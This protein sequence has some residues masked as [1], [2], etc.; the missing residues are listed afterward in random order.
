MPLLAAGSR[1]ELQVIHWEQFIAGDNPVRVIDSF[2][3][4]LDLA[5][6]GFV[7]KGKSREGRPAFSSETLLKLYLYGYLNRCR[8]SR[9]LMRA[10]QTNIELFWLLHEAKPCYKTIAD[11]R[12]NN[13]RALTKTFSTFSQ[14]L[15]GEGLLQG[16]TV[17]VDGTKIA[18]QNSKKN[19][20]NAKKIKRH[21][22]YIDRQT[23]GYLRE[24][25]RLDATE[26]TEEEQVLEIAEKLD[27]LHQR[28]EKYKG[29]EKQLNAVRANHQAQIST[30]DPEARA[31]P[32]KMNIVEVS[33]NIQT[34]VESDHKLITNFEVT[35]ENDTHALS[36]M[37]IEAKAV[38][39]KERIKVLADKGYDTESELKTCSEN[40]I[41]TYV[42][43]R[44]KNTSK[45][46]PEFVKAQ[47]IYDP[48]KDS[49]TCPEN[50]ELRSNGNRYKKNVKGHRKAYTVQ[51]YKLPLAECKDCVHRLDCVGQANLDN[52]KGRRIERSE[53]DDYLE[54][55]RE[56]VKLHKALYRTRQQ[57]V[58]HPFGTIKR[59]W[60]YSYTLLKTKEKVAAEMAL[61][62]TCYN[63]RRSMSIFGVS[64]LVKR[65]KAACLHILGSKAAFLSHLGL[66]FSKNRMPGIFLLKKIG[67]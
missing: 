18:A 59:G 62:F 66:V 14:F 49:Y 67:L 43:P 54:A 32:K 45:K 53:Y 46:H 61:I 31:L 17:A 3:D 19:N 12:K 26:T 56:R 16:N 15:R 48:E 37:A 22:D 63:I 47:F 8:S 36:S 29:L 64:D 52:S 10:A 4:L 25:N 30:T 34:A 55:N 33:Y 13:T 23:Q 40:K 35:N 50:K 57:I 20:Y 11:F 39:K 65:L 5:Q 41:E 38:L 7:I 2:V 6:L 24:M 44:Q 60:G 27:Q 28:K 51:V 9:Q 58:E 42:A 1:T 21:L